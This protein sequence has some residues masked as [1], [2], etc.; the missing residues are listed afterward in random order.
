MLSSIIKKNIQLIDYE[1]I[2]H[3]NGKRVIAFGKFAGNSG[4][5]D[6][7]Y[8]LGQFLL[9]KGLGNQ[10]LN[11]CQSYH[12]FNID[13]AKDHIRRVGKNIEYQGLP[14]DICPFIVGVTGY[15]NCS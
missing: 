6:I 10:F 9:N 4:T 5:I 14:I 15:G 7:L 8:G 11:I 2:K 3:K 12:Y 13:N 1:K